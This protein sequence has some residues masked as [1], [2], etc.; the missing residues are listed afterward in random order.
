MTTTFTILDGVD[1]KELEASIQSDSVRFDAGAVA[2]HLGWTLKPE[3]LCQE[4][5]CIPVRDREAL[6][7]DDGIDLSTLAQ[8]LGRPLAVD[9]AERAAALGTPHTSRAA[10]MASLE[11]PDFELPDIDGQQHRLSDHRGKKVL[12]IA[13]ASW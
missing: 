2:D 7:D 6:V 12:L 10:E 8:L 5:V 11:A 1:A 13:Y 4:N 3:G 9:V